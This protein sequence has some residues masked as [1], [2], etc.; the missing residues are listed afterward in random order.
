[1]PGEAADPGRL[2]RHQEKHRVASGFLGKKPEEH[3]KEARETLGHFANRKVHA[4]RAIKKY[5]QP[6]NNL[7]SDY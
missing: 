5:T 2:Q 7:I 3:V 6:S 1:L 4:A